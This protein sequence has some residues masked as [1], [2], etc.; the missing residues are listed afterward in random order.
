MVTLKV[1]DEKKLKKIQR[2]QTKKPRVVVTTPKP[3]VVVTAPNES[4]DDDGATEMKLN[5][6]SEPSDEEDEEI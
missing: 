4:S 3:R 2:Q 1:K 5:D 6:S